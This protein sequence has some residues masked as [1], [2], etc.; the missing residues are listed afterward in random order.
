MSAAVTVTVIVLNRDGRGFLETCLTSIQAQDVD[1]GCRT[2]L[3]D[4]GST[5][6]SAGFVRDRFPEIEVIETGRN[7]GFAGGN[8]AG[9]RRASTPF[10]LLLNNDTRMRPGCLQA[11]LAAAETSPAVG[12]VQAKLV[13]QDRPG[14]LQS[15]GTLLLSDGSAGDRGFGEPDDGRFAQREEVFA[16]CGA[17]SL[18]SREALAEV[19]LLD[20][21]FFLY[22]EDTDLSWRLRLAGWKVL[23]EPAAVVEHAHAGT[24]GAD[25]ALMRFHADRNRLLMVLKNAPWG[26]VWSSYRS[27][28]A[29]A[30]GA[31]GETKGHPRERVLTSFLWHV[32]GA[33]AGR[34]RIRSRRRVPD[35]DV[36]RWVVPRSDWDARC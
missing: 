5:D 26:F 35:Q 19:G 9:L 30:A 29:R 11:L 31:G 4:N 15:T 36:L 7:L 25:S 27:L 1:G 24:T 21:S 17:A 6:G 3:V 13:F 33:L 18:Y 2:V 16:A 32:P 34:A 10:V 20:E 14:V 12:A 22:Y 28:G 8:N 23:Y